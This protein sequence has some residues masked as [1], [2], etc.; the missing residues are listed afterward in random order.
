MMYLCSFLLMGKM[1]VT[2]LS[3][4]LKVEGIV[5]GCALKN[6]TF[7]TFFFVFSYCYAM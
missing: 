7:H 4:K 2:V 3:G 1:F 5:S 6:A